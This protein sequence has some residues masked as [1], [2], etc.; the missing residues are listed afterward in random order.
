VLHQRRLVID[1]GCTLLDMMRTQRLGDQSVEQ[2]AACLGS[3]AQVRFKRDAAPESKDPPG[4]REAARTYGPFRLKI[5][6]GSKADR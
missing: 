3:I 6:G 1:D 4:G 2:T 5:A